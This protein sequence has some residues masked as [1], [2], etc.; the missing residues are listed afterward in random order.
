MHRSRHHWLG[1]LET[2]LSGHLRSSDLNHHSVR[3]LDREAGGLDSPFV[4]AQ[5]VCVCVCKGVYECVCVYDHLGSTKMPCFAT[6]ALR[7]CSQGE[8]WS[9]PQDGGRL[10]TR[11]SVD[12]SGEASYWCTA[13][14]AHASKMVHTCAYT[15]TQAGRHRHTQLQ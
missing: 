3:T 14:R 1:P 13:E 9:W 10:R 5:C 15:G 8:I 12:W 6:K 11:R 2:I 4:C 7:R